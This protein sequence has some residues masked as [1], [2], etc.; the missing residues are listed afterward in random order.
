MKSEFRL[1]LVFLVPF[2]SGCAAMSKSDCL[3]ANWEDIGKEDA[4][5]GYKG[6]EDSAIIGACNRHSVKINYDEYKYGYRQGVKSYCEP[7]TALWLGQNGQPINK[8]CF[9]VTGHSRALFNLS[10]A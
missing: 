9:K 10:I 3:N 1:W 6:I 8:A 4:L 2:I 7:S 5:A